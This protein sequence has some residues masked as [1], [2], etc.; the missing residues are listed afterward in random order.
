V[1]NYQRLK[2][3]VMRSAEKGESKEYTHI[4]RKRQHQ[5]FEEVD[6]VIAPCGCRGGCVACLSA[7]I[8]KDIAELL[9]KRICPG[10]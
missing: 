4:R 9:E 8:G 7:S 5:Y 1:V 10:A 3:I 2:S 6:A